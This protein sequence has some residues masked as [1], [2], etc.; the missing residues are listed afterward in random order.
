[1]GLDF[2]LFLMCFTH[3]QLYGNLRIK[4]DFSAQWFLNPVSEN[5]C[6]MILSATKVWWYISDTCRIIIEY[7]WNCHFY[8]S[9][10]SYIFCCFD[11]YDG[12]LFFIFG[13][14]REIG[15]LHDILIYLRY[16]PSEFHEIYNRIWRDSCIIVIQ[17][18]HTTHC[19]LRDLATISNV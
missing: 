9:V 10:T 1:M 14:A 19:S 4:Y 6:K 17:Y 11:K 7:N 3:K 12:C 18:T 16:W 8:T 13:F 15:C 2:F 5:E